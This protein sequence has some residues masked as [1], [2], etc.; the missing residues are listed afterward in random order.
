MKYEIIISAKY[1]KKKR[2]LKRIAKKYGLTYNG[3]NRAGSAYAFTCSG[4]V[5][6][7][8]YRKLIIVCAQKKLKLKLQNKFATR[9]TNYRQAFFDKHT[10]FIGPYYFCAYC[11]KLISRKKTTVD[12]LYPVNSAQKSINIQKRLKRKGWDSINDERN[13]VAACETCNKR[14]AAKTGIWI[15]KGQIGRYN[16]LWVFRHIIRTCIAL[17]CIYLLW[18]A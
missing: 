7:K 15:L 9:S 14:K 12:H 3:W 2:P 4:M 18:L 10:P 1:K 5:T 6:E 13:L 11:G 17:V 8:E 16:W